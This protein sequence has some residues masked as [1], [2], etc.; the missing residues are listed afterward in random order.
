MPTAA[1]LKTLFNLNETA[2]TGYFTRGRHWPAHINPIFGQIGGGSWVWIGGESVSEN[3]PAFNFAWS[4]EFVGDV[5][6]RQ[7]TK[8][9][10][11]GDFRD[12]EGA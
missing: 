12:V 2:G 4:E 6:F 5:G 1:Q 8:C 9:V 3:A 7:L 11:Q 10:V